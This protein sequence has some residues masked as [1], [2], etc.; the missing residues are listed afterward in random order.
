[1]YFHDMRKFF[2]DIVDRLDMLPHKALFPNILAIAYGRS[3]RAILQRHSFSQTLG[4]VFIPSFS[5][6][7][8]LFRHLACMAARTFLHGLDIILHYSSLFLSFWPKR[9]WNAGACFF[10]KHIQYANFVARA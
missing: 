1:M 2:M 10:Q 7:L 4:K 3:A 5:A 8:V 9:S 6:Y